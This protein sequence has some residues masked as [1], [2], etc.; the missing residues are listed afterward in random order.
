MSENIKD[1][2]RTIEESKKKNIPNIF[3]NKVPQNLSI[4]L[5]R[6]LEETKNEKKEEGGGSPNMY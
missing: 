6:D 1:T 5:V 3:I 4:S 2:T